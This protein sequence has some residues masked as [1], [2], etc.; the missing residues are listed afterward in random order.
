MEK[1]SDKDILDII[2]AKLSRAELHRLFLE[3]GISDTDVENAERIADSRDIGLQAN[4]VLKMWRE[5]IGKNATRRRIINALTE[6]SFMDAKEIL[7]E[8]WSLI[9]QGKYQN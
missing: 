6:C 8:K 2:K 1:L 9:V 4:K 5:K 3:L 7:E